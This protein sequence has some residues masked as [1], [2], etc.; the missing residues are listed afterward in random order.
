MEKMTKVQKFELVK[1]VIEGEV[2]LTDEIKDLILETMD[3]EIELT[4]K[5]RTSKNSKKDKEMTEFMEKVYNAL[6]E[7]GKPSTATEVGDAIKESNQ[8]ASSYLRKLKDAGRVTS[9]T[10][11]RKTY[12][13]INEDDEEVIE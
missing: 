1:K 8:K 5:K 2:E 9:K 3:H 13:M 4:S 12:F 11:K 10:E 7:L 6:V